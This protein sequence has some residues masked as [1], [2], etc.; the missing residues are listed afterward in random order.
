LVNSAVDDDLLSQED[1]PELVHANALA[2]LINFQES[3][4]RPFD[5]DDIVVVGEQV[6]IDEFELLLSREDEP[7]IV[8]FLYFVGPYALVQLLN[9]R[10]HLCLVVLCRQKLLNYLVQIRQFF[11]DNEMKIVEFSVDVS[12][13]ALAKL[14]FFL[15]AD[16]A[17]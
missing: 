9:T 2:P 7:N 12:K 17:V 10:E 3:L 13:F 15:P 16:D 11:L 14:N 4:L 8:F 5:G 1:V 6:G